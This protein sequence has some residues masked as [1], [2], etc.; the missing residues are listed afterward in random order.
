MSAADPTFGEREAPHPFN[1]I[2]WLIQALWQYKWLAVAI[3]AIGLA[4]AYVLA[5]RLP[6]VYTAS[7]LLEIDP[8]TEAVLPNNRTNTFVPPETITETE[9]QVIRS[10]RVLREV[11]RALGEAPG[12]TVNVSTQDDPALART[13]ADLAQSLTVRPTGRS[14]VVEISYESGNPEEAARVV[15]TVMQEYLGVEV[16]AAR[17]LSNE[18]IDLLSERLAVL[19]ADLDEKERAVQEFRRRSALAEGAGTNILSEQLARLNEE[20]IRAQ[21]ALAS[22]AASAVSTTDVSDPALLP[23]VVNSLLIQRLREQEATQI[24]T[25]DELETLYRATHPRLI[26]ARSSLAATRDTIAVEMRKIASSLGTTEAVQ[27]RRVAAL[28]REVETLRD[29]F[30]RQRDLEIELRRLDREVDASRR[31]YEAFLDRFNEVQGT[32]GFER[33]EGRIIAAA[34]PPVSPSG[35]NRLFVLA[36]GGILSGA[37]AFALIVGMALLD[38]RMR[39]GADVSRASGL[40]P[41]AV[42]PPVPG[43]RFSVG[44]RV[45]ARSRNARFADAITQLRAVLL[46]GSGRSDEFVVGITASGDDADH[47]SLALALAQA[48]AVAGDEVML[49]DAMF[50]APKIHELLGTPNE[51]GLSDVLTGDGDLEPAVQLDPQSSLLYLPAGRTADPSIYRSNAM[52]A[53][54]GDIAETFSTV[55]IVLPPI[56]EQPD[57]QSLVSLCDV[58]AIVV[59]A[60]AS[61][62]T[63]LTDLVSLLRYSGYRGRLAT[64]LVRD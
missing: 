59:R 39:T 24:R 11:V 44:D 22:A 54:V 35:P 61:R 37:A 32:T 40:T 10:S 41:I 58:T 52:D 6:D 28:E 42:V 45:F 1:P 38:R 56:P 14:F 21:A 30:N 5:S 49:V 31:V 2:L 33:P 25:V 17:D 8:A 3:V 7:G 57:A 43:G 4:A 51:Y 62:R 12:A 29:R 63:E 19:R 64:V 23:E 16:T 60:G 55:I 53:F 34:L 36:G 50:S 47:A 9:V 26:Q 20:L 15:N 48:A 46:L 13:V 27:G 18:A